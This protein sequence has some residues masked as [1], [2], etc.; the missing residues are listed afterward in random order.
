MESELPKGWVRT[1]LADIVRPTRPKRAPQTVPHLPFIGMEHVE[2]HTMRLLGTGAAASMRSAGVHFQPGDVLY[3]RLRP[4]LN[5][6]CRPEFEGL[7]SAE[8]IVLCANDAVDAKFLQ[9]RLNAADF[10]FFASHLD[11][12]DRPRVD[13]QQIGR[14]LIDLPP[15]AEQRRIAAALEEHLSDLDAAVAGLERARANVLRYSHAVINTGVLGKLTSGTAVADRVSDTVP[16]HWQW[17]E[18]RQLG[19]L[20][21]GL[22]KGQRRRSGTALRS[23]PYLRVANVQRGYLDLTEVKR[24]AATEAEIEELRLQPGD[25]LFN[26]GGDRDKLGRGWI[27]SGELAECIYQNHVFRARVDRTRVEPKFLSYYANSH[28]QHYFMAEGK[29]TTNLASINLTK[30]GALPIPVPPV[31][32]QRAIVAEIDR[33]L[34]ITDRTAAEI[35]LQLARAARLRQSILKHAFEG[36]LVP[37]DPADEPATALLERIRTEHWS[38]NQSAR[39]SHGRSRHRATRSR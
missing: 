5:K 25:V 14:F 6:V 29:Q 7:C 12:G 30:L 15:L 31:D 4:Y 23:V 33:R 35:D 24:I 3:G 2:A 26:E 28:G 8:F 13:Y 17:A 38:G 19:A 39:R 34:A 36:K 27:W 1:A 11:E 20:K 32:E 9:Y 21:G 22:T 16:G 37:Q 18:L 10:V